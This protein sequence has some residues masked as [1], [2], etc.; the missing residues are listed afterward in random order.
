[1]MNS[2]NFV[3]LAILVT[4]VI[5]SFVIPAIMPFLLL[6]FTFANFIFLIVYA[7]PLKI[8]KKDIEERNF[9]LKLASII[10][11]IIIIT[12]I[13]LAEFYSNPAPYLNKPDTKNYNYLMC[14]LASLML[15]FHISIEQSLFVTFKERGKSLPRISTLI[16]LGLLLLLGITVILTKGLTTGFSLLK[17]FVYIGYILLTLFPRY[18]MLKFLLNK[19]ILSNYN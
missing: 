3:F 10:S 7:K 6:T 12:G 14:T 2:V 9:S 1:M 13:L 4:F 11:G 15:L 17:Y 5:L 19:K 8:L 18:T 16:L